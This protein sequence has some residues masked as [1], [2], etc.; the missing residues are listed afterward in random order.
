M[1]IKSELQELV[2]AA[3]KDGWSTAT[4]NLD[5]LRFQAQWTELTPMSSRRGQGQVDVLRPVDARQ[6]P[7]RSLSAKYGTGQQPLHTDGAHL[8]IPPDIVIL[9][10]KQPSPVPTMLWRADYWR[11]KAEIREDL[12]H[13]LF[14]VDDGMARFLAPAYERGRY[15]FD[16]GCMTPADTRARR[17][18]EYFGDALA[19]ATRFDWT[20]PS[21]VLVI[22]NRTVLHARAD[23]AADPERALERI[24]FR[25]EKG[26]NP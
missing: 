23:A 19:A 10:A 20:E 21:Q 26:G 8:S 25:I 24:M 13:G 15:R 2:A 12:A 6:A 4:G 11:S 1:A 7:R 22:D 9:A 18:S 17:V 3:R 16:P 14:A 5:V